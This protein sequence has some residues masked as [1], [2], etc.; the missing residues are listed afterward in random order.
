MD[1]SQ[2]GEMRDCVMQVNWKVVGRS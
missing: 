1:E 2:G